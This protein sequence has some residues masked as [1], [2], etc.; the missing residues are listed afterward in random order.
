MAVLPRVR[1]RLEA[2]FRKLD[3]LYPDARFPPVTIVVGR[4]KTVGVADETGVM[5]GLEALR[6]TKWLNPNVEERS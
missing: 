6:G 3:Q 5:I 4:A 2:S 1:E